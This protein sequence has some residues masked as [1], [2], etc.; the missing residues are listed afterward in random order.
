MREGDLLD[1]SLAQTPPC[2]GNLVQQAMD[3][4]FIRFFA[5]GQWLYSGLWVQIFRCLQALYVSRVCQ[6]IKFEEWIFPRVIPQE[7]M[8][9]F[10]LTHY[11]PGMLFGV[12]AYEKQ[13][14]F[15]GIL[16]PV[17][18]VPIYQHLRGQLLSPEILPLKIVECLGGWTWRNERSDGLDGPIRAREFARVESVFIGSPEQVRLL[19]NDV[20]NEITSLLDELELSWRVVV[21][22]GCMEIP[23]LLQATEQA[24]E[25]GEVP[26][27]DIEVLI[28]E[29]EWLEI[30]G[31]TV[32]GDH[33]IDSF[34]ICTEGEMGLWSGCCGI[35]MNRLL[36]C[37]FLQHGFE[38]SN[39]PESVQKLV[40]VEN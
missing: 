9:S 13:E 5:E 31:C 18:C 2:G 24:R 26:V 36:A 10:E 14:G 4:G 28:G 3:A 17:Q 6:R 22:V 25:S 23:S 35:G 29:D 20:K 19:R 7:A 1:S 34:G 11:K 21:G 30:A 40:G 8:E 33:L 12:G 27:H 39:W 32:E 15:S 37:L 38:L 16:D